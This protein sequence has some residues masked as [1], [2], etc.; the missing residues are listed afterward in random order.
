MLKTLPRALS[1][2]QLTLN[3]RSI[4]R[5]QDG[6]SGVKNNKENPLHMGEAQIFVFG[7]S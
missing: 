5:I 7:V 4:H 3:D 2:S 1:T 6:L